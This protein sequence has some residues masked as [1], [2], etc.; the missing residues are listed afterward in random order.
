MI[1]NINRNRLNGNRNIGQKNDSWKDY[2]FYRMLLL[3]LY[4]G[5]GLILRMIGL[6]NYPTL[7]VLAFAVL[8]VW[9]A[10]KL[11]DLARD[12]IKERLP[13]AKYTCILAKIG[14]VEAAIL[15]VANFI[16]GGKIFQ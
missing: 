6:G 3:A 7:A 4:I 14:L 8:P 2:I 9:P 13:L 10:F 5:G 12:A 1:N 11:L 15:G 16:S